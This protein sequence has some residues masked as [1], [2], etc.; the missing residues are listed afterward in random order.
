M[1]DKISRC[2]DKF[3]TVIYG[4]FGA[5]LSTAMLLL[6]NELNCIYPQSIFKLVAGSYKIYSAQELKKL[7]QLYG[8]FM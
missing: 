6:K 7:F 3:F 8:G 5:N 1:L 2:Q 4:K